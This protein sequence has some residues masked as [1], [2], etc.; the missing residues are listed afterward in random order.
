MNKELNVLF[1]TNVPSPYRVLFFNELG[2]YCNLTVLYQRY[3]SSERDQKWVSSTTGN[4]TIKVLKGVKTGVD[5]AFC[6]SVLHFLNRKFDAIIICGISSPTEMLAIEYCRIMKIPYCI[7][8]DGAFVGKGNRFKDQIKKHFIKGGELFF[9]TCKNHD[10]YYQKYGAN[11]NN[12]YRYNF[13][14]VVEKDILKKTL[15]KKEKNEIRIRLGIKESFVVLA[16]GQ[17]IPRKGFDVLLEAMREEKNL[18]VYIVGGKPTEQYSRYVSNNEMTNVHFVEFLDKEHLSD[19]YKMAD[20]FVHPTREDI[21]GLVVNE[22][23]SK[24]LPVITTTRCNAG[25]EL[26]RN[27]YNGFLIPPDNPDQLK[28]AI[29]NAINSNAVLSINSLDCVRNY[30]IEKMAEQHISIL[31]GNTTNTNKND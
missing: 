28:Q 25:L 17:F 19:Y 23:L 10:A 27:G 30:T 24:G 5:N 8:G 26:I 7:E 16:V 4:Y 14:S 18:G 12:I 20:V 29:I 31:L 3:Q 22:A 11:E 6:P 13:T 1:L 15:T 9:S 21:W 2:K